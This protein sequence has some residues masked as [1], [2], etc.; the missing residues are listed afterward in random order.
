MKQVLIILIICFLINCST[1]QDVS[2]KDTELNSRPIDKTTISST[3]K[4]ENDTLKYDFCYFF[5]EDT[6]SQIISIKLLGISKKDNLPTNLKFNLTL[7]N[8]QKPGGNFLLNGIAV[9]TSSEET[10]SDQNEIDEGEYFA[11]DYIFN[12]DDYKIKIRLDIEEYQ[13]CV[14]SI[15]CNGSKNTNEDYCQYV[16]KYPD[17]DVM[18]KTDCR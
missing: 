3:S 18:K 7:K 12:S 5:S 13:A 8:K 11:A 9:L 1:K 6:I 14:V 2:Q 10:F 17:Y 4:E 16:K 15:A